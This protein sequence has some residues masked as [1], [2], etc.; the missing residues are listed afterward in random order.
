MP[1]V[2]SRVS[3]RYRVPEGLTDVIGHLEALSPVVVVRTKSGERVELSPADVVSVRELSHTPVRNSQIRDLERT[4]ALARPAA[5]Q[6]WA[7]GWL[8]RAD[9]EDAELRSN[10]AAPL[11]FSAGLGTLAQIIEWYAARGLPPWLDLPERLLPVRAAGAHPSRMMTCDRLAE[12]DGPIDPAVAVTASGL[13]YLRI[14]EDD[15]PR[16]ARFESLG[17]RLHHRARYVLA[18][19]LV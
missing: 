12:I 14:P 9:V 13:A 2:G 3:L 16:I 19:D 5:E 15:A 17:F 11:E 7:A 10:S 4:A 1:S 8:L 6:Q 18:T